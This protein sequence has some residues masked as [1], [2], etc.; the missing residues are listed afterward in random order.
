MNRLAAEDRLYWL[1]QD[2]VLAEFG[3]FALKSDDLDK[4][5]AEACRSVG[6][7]LAI[8]LATVLELQD[9]GRTLL[10]RAGTGWQPELLGR[11]TVE[12]ADGSL[13]DRTLTTGVPATCPDIE[14]LARFRIAP[15]LAENGVR[16]IANVIIPGGRHGLAFGILQV[17]SQSPR[18]FTD[19]DIGVLR[20]YA[21]LLASAVERVRAI[22][23]LHD[24][25]M[26][27]R[28]GVKWQQA[29]S[30]TGLIGFFDW[31]L[32]TD[33]ITGDAQ[34]ASFYGLEPRDAAAGVP[35]STILALVHPDDRPASDANVAEATARP[36]DFA[37]TFRL[38]HAD[39]TTRWLLARGQ[40]HEYEDGTPLSYTGT[41]VD[42]T[43]L[44]AAEA[45]LRRSN[46]VLEAR[47]A[48]RTRELIESHERL[49]IAAEEREQ[50]EQALRQS[51][52]MEA[53]G[54]LTGGLAHDFNNLLTAIS[55]SL[56][57]IAMRASQGRIGEIGRYLAAA[58]ESARR[59]ATL[60]AR[61]LAF[62]RRQTLDPSS[63]DINQ[64]VGGMSDML[65]Q[66]MGPTIAM[67]FK[68][69]TGLWPTLCDVN[70]LESTLLNL[71]IN[72]RH[73]MP[74]GG[75]LV[76]ETGNAVVPDRHSKSADIFLAGAAPGDYVVLRVADTG[77]GMTPEV[78]ARAFDPF[79]TTKPLGQG[80]GLG[81]S[82]IHGFVQQS[83]GQVLLRS[84]ERQGTTVTIYLPRH[85]VATR[86]N[87]AHGASVRTPGNETAAVVLV[88]EDEPAV[89][90]I[91]VAVLEDLGYA[92]LQAIDG[93]SALDLVGGSAQIDLLVTDV[94]LP[95]GINGRQLA[96]A[97]R[98]SRPDL[99]VLFIT[100]YANGAAVGGL[101]D[102]GMGLLTK[103]FSKEAL[104]NTAQAMLRP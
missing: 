55:G 70:Q 26:R 18:L 76:I 73:A 56:E 41:A 69:A 21:A 4:T 51:R 48:E 77:H 68:P 88:V 65:R 53:V 28:Q 64:M 90:M 95:G 100:G 82:M 63:I 60:T 67:Q 6:E 72:A 12:V 24:E 78:L 3:E 58:Q 20:S 36:T 44:K 94:G 25:K 23:S 102:Q 54:Q 9:G 38:L 34:F 39:G 62:S 42:I 74:D 61:L 84:A 80:T 49:R 35:L 43:A 86:G 81:L 40:C 101:M 66:T 50:V 99:K 8:D 5:L 75:A 14:A 33:T 79:F 7:V 16:A 46:E 87:G 57:M 15:F 17:G 32:A 89:C 47:V 92:V 27:A 103:P 11:V 52:K 45:V 30:A 37:R 91:L 19:E 96:D 1:R 31:H 98:R 97:V 22:R 71:A 2:A 10:V 104:A 13:E 83:G 93:R 29:A 59:A 85:V